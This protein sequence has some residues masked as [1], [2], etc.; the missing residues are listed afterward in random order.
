MLQARGYL[1]CA[2]RGRDFSSGCPAGLWRWGEESGEGEAV[3]EGREKRLCFL[4]VDTAA[5]GGCVRYAGGGPDRQEV[6][7]ATLRGG[8]GVF[9]ARVCVHVPLWPP[10]LG[11]VVGWLLFFVGCLILLPE[12]T[13]EKGMSPVF[14]PK[15]FST[16]FE[17]KRATVLFLLV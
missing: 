3:P 17:Q 4:H 6:P 7:D 11:S 8:L 9:D 12:W 10:F 14:R 5:R 16:A 15:G 13:C 2:V 1:V